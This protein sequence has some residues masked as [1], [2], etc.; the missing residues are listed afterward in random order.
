[1]PFVAAAILAACVCLGAQGSPSPAASIQAAQERV[2]RGFAAADLSPF[3]AVASRY[4][5][6]GDAARLV[7]QGGAASFV[8][9]SGTGGAA[10]AAEVTFDGR[11]IWVAPVAGGTPLALV[12]RRGESGV[13]AGKGTPIAGRTR[14]GDEDLVRVGRLYLETGAPPGTGRAIVYDPQAPARKAFTGL[15]WFAASTALQAKARFVPNERPDPIVVTTSRGLQKEF[16]RVGSFA[17]ALEGRA[18]RL[19][20]LATSA[21]PKKGEELFVPFRDETTGH[22]SYAVGRYL[23]VAFAGAAAEYLIDFNLATNPY[24]AYSPHYN[25]VIPPKENTLPVAIRAGEM[26][27]ARH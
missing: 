4:F 12:K 6:G 11:E 23:N 22:E 14:I 2:A 21:Q 19:T 8:D 9:P 20:A 25:C 17:F 5:S 27:Y 10:A 3:T 7:L 26:V 18:L 15:R 24:C 1:M 13:A 16:F